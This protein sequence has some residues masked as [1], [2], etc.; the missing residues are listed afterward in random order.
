MQEEESQVKGTQPDP[1]LQIEN[2]FKLNS[3]LASVKAHFARPDARI[4]VDSIIT[5]SEGDAGGRI[6]VS[7]CG[8][9]GLCD[10]SREA[11]KARI[12]QLSDA[13][14]L[15]YHEETFNW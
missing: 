13:S 4:Y 3:S 12:G 15:V 10:T 9:L 2:R 11:V 8:P 7:A 1:L 14:R 6:A 5:Q